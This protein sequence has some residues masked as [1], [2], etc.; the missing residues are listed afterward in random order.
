MKNIACII[1]AAGRGERMKSSI[2]KVLHPICGRTMLGYVLNVVRDLKINKVIVV[3]RH[4]HEEAK[5]LIGPGIKIVIQ[6][7]ILGTADA[8]KQAH[9]VL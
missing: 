6:K 5:K 9:V 1:L 7:R 2:P 3:L 8:V 4:R